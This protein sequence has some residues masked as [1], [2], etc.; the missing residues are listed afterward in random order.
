[1]KKILIILTVLILTIALFPKVGA[2][3]TEEERIMYLIESTAQQEGVDVSFCKSIARIESN[4]LN[5][6]FNDNTYHFVKQKNISHERYVSRGIM[7]L[8]IATAKYFN[9][10]IKTRQDLYDSNKNI[11]AGVRYI[12]YLFKKY[13]KYS[14]GQ[15]AQ[16]YN[17]GET[18]YLKGKRNSNYEKKFVKWYEFYS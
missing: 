9:K 14:Y 15:I 8:T 2:S 5:K 4:F 16:L 13:P 17:L 6:A 10:D 11:V 3:I 12:K 7:Q 18:S 1:M